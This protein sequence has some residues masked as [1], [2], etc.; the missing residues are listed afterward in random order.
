MLKKIREIIDLDINC[1]FLSVG[2]SPQ[3]MTWLTQYLLDKPKLFNLLTVNLD[4]LN[5]CVYSFI[6]YYILTTIS[7]PS[8]LPGT[9]PSTPILFSSIPLQKMA[10]LPEIPTK[11]VI[12]NCSKTCLCIKVGQSNT[13]RKKS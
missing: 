4:L 1:C 5:F 11:N 10:G 7:F 2:I 12:L 8:S 9:F 3:I 13:T 6:I